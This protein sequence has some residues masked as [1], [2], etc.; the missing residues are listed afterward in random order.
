MTPA[1]RYASVDSTIPLCVY[2]V[3]MEA[4]PASSWNG[5]IAASGAFVNV[6]IRALSEEQVVLQAKQVVE[7]AGWLLECVGPAKLLDPKSPDVVDDVRQYY[8]Q[9]LVDEVVVVIHSWRELH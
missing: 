3:T 9:C 1:N 8:E 7:A 4:R 2:V 5:E 6:Y